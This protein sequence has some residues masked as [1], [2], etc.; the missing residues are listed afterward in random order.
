M[1]L[2]EGRASLPERTP[3]APLVAPTR[4]RWVVV[5]AVLAVL[6][7]A[8]LSGARLW[9]AITADIVV[10]A[11]ERDGVAY[12]RPLVQLVAVTAD[13]Q[14]AAVAGKPVDGGRLRDAVADVSAVQARFGDRLSTSVRLQE[15]S[16]R[17]TALGEASPTGARAFAEYSQ[18]VDLE[19]ALVRAVG[20]TSTLILDPVLDSYYVMDTTLLRVPELLVNAGLIVDRATLNS[21]PGGASAAGTSAAAKAAAQAVAIDI[22]TSRVQLQNDA[23]AADEGLRKSLAVTASRTLGSALVSRVDRLRA[24]IAVLAPPT[25]E[26][27]V[28]PVAATAAQLAAARGPVRDNAVA[29]EAGGLDQLDLLLAARQSQLESERRLVFGLLAAGAA[30]AVGCWWVLGLRR[31]AEN[32][33]D[34]ADL[35]DEDGPEQPEV[36]EEP[37]L[38]EARDLLESRRLVRVGRA[39]SPTREKP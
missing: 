16:D 10:V 32:D 24:A 28:A 33:P 27:G 37:E 21:T 38:V 25:A 8:A 1:Q 11:K 30:L 2:S 26:V 22:A 18:L 9:N 35:D 7:P 36:E 4:R 23:A 29:L 19:L 39:V 17:V 15:I 13:V 31:R 34:D 14:S 20:D 5:V 12:L 6:L 3:P